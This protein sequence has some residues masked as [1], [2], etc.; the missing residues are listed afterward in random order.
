MRLIL[1]LVVLLI[2]G[3]LIVK[4][5]DSSSSSAEYEG[6]ISD[7]NTTIPKIPTTPQNVE[8][9]KEGINQLMLDTANER[10]KKIDE[11]L[12]N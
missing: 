8:T 6:I 3:F 1:L 12:A 9:F 5:L 2:I 10:A 4:Q 7:E 11:S